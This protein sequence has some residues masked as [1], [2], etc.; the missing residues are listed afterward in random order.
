MVGRHLHRRPRNL[1]RL[2][3]GTV[4]D[5]LSSSG[6]DYCSRNRLFLAY[7]AFSY[8][9]STDNLIIFVENSLQPR[10][11]KRKQKP[12]PTKEDR[13]AGGDNPRMGYLQ[14]SRGNLG[15]I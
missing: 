9:F 14:T 13:D 4:C 3:N 12:P 11:N 1:R 8:H 15:A 7:S 10:D 2:A 6:G 5:A